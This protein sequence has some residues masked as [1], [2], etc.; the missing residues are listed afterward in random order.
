MKKLSRKS[1]VTYNWFTK[2]SWSCNYPASKSPTFKI[3]IKKNLLVWNGYDFL[4]IQNI[5]I[6]CHVVFPENLNNK[7]NATNGYKHKRH[8]L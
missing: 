5:D 7:Q 2:L 6:S 1:S 8:R 3:N 4:G